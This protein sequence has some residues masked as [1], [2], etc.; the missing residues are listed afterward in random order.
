[1]FFPGLRNRPEWISTSHQ[2]SHSLDQRVWISHLDLTPP[3]QVLAAL[4]SEYRQLRGVEGRMASLVVHQEAAVT[5]LQLRQRLGPNTA[6]TAGL[7]PPSSAE[8][9]LVCGQQGLTPS[10][11]A[12]EMQLRPVVVGWEGGLDTLGRDGALTRPSSGAVT[13]RCNLRAARTL[14]T[15]LRAE[16][17]QRQLMRQ[18]RSVSG[19]GQ[20]AEGQQQGGAAKFGSMAVDWIGRDVIVAVPASDASQLQPLVEH[21]LMHGVLLRIRPGGMMAGPPPGGG[22]QAM[23]GLTAG[24]AGPG[25]TA[26]AMVDVR[27]WDGDASVPRVLS[28]LPCSKVWLLEEACRAGMLD[29]ALRQGAFAQ[30]SPVAVNLM[31]ARWVRPAHVSSSFW[32]NVRP[33][34]SSSSSSSEPPE[35]S[36]VQGDGGGNDGGQGGCGTQRRR[37]V[38]QELLVGG[39]ATTAA[40]AAPSALKP[41]VHGVD[42][43]AVPAAAAGKAPVSASVLRTSKS[44]SRTAHLAESSPGAPSL[45]RTRSRTATQAS[46]PTPPGDAG[47]G[48]DPGCGGMQAL[49]MI[50]ARPGGSNGKALAPRKSQV[51]AAKGLSPAPVF[52]TVRLPFLPLTVLAYLT[53]DEALR[54]A[55]HAEDPWEDLARHWAA[56]PDSGIPVR[57]RPLLAAHSAVGTS[58][59]GQPWRPRLPGHAISLAAVAQA[60]VEALF[61]GDGPKQLAMRLSAL[62]AAAAGG[63]GS[64]VPQQQPA[65]GRDE[66]AVLLTGFLG[67]FGGIAA[68]RVALVQAVMQ[69]R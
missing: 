51:A 27:V 42:C 57:L 2:I 68:H 17:Q 69:S 61:A 25:M 36:A 62:T 46:Q 29:D 16:Q 35:L 55:L 48:S 21:C 26:A 6:E 60:L 4:L 50:A 34:S 38:V 47:G 20:G 23:G 43:M 59:P 30:L 22:Q 14:E 13:C 40:A 10:A 3:L 52:L 56:R 19:Y 15:M 28:G 9:Q 65:I 49:G 32:T 41:G 7:V 66:A 8:V 37:K 64:T 24:P 18:G 31:P 5:G 63:G 58:A 53:G 11:G 39:P 45:G 54:S 67:A 1:M 12:V 44:R 33:G